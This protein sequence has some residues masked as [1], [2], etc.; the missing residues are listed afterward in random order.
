MNERE[1]PP[2]RD[3]RQEMTN[4]VISL[5][6]SGTAPWQQPWEGGDGGLPYNPTTNK[7]YRGGNVLGLMITSMVRGYTDPRFCTFKQALDNGWCVRK[8][9]K[10]SKIEYW[11]P[12][13]GSKDEGADEDEKRSRLIH[14][15]YTVFNAQQIEGIPPLHIVPRK[16][17]EIIDAAENALKASGADIRHGGAKAYYSPRTDH[18]QMPPR[19]CFVDEAHYYSTALHELAH[20]TGAKDRLDRTQEKGAFGTPE[21]AKEEIRADMASLFLSAE[22]GIPYDPVDQAGY[23]SN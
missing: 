21:Y 12:K 23:I 7:P 15:V 6:E 11:E 2:P 13:L 19:E 10:G 1:K 16:P 3:H 20:W 14:R 22:L 18:I 9:E 5:P 4:Q 8:C 17:F